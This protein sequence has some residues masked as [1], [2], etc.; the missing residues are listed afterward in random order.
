MIVTISI[1]RLQRSVYV[2]CYVIPNGNA[3]YLEKLVRLAENYFMVLFQ[4]LRSYIKVYLNK[5][6][7]EYLF[8]G[9]EILTST[10]QMRVWSADW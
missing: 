7:L 2:I 1:H 8:L 4:H 9:S 5:F 6:L 3:I 10:S